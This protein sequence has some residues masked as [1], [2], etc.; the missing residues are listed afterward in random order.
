MYLCNITERCVIHQNL[1]KVHIVTVNI[2]LI[3]YEPK[4]DRGIGR[5]GAGGGGGQ[6]VSKN[7][8]KAMLILNFVIS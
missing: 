6:I 4:R 7:I 5:G 1:I 3:Y 2:K 8:I